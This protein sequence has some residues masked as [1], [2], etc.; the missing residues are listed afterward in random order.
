MIIP[1]LND[2]LS[3]LRENFS[4][5]PKDRKQELKK[6]SR[7]VELKLKEGKEAALVFICTHNSR[8]SHMSQL[9]AQAAAAYYQIPMVKSYSGGTEATAFN[10]RAVR[11][12]EKAGFEISEGSEGANPVYLVKYALEAPPMRAFSKVFDH[13]ENPKNDFAAIMTCSH[14]DE[15]C[16]LIPGA[17]V[18]LPIRYQDPK[19]FDDTALEAQKYLERSRQVALEML[20]AFGQVKV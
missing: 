14:A 6:L 15:N 16:P 20:Y 17:S 1:P 8:R 2:Y 13:E 10:P 9:W 11:A 18:R 7:F 5:I 3:S 4:E 19:E 12:M